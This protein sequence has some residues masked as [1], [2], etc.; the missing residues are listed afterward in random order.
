MS[1]LVTSAKQ[2]CTPASHCFI[3]HL[4]GGGQCLLVRDSEPIK[5]IE[6]PTSLSLYMLMVNKR[7]KIYCIISISDKQLSSFFISLILSLSFYSFLLFSYLFRFN[8]VVS[9]LNV[10]ILFRRHIWAELSLLL[11]TFLSGTFFPGGGGSGTCTQCT[12]C[13]CACSFIWESPPGIY[14]YLIS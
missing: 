8:F 13:I 11:W 10:H 7:E 4:I 9:E 6:I 5:L 12:P 1:F 3:I 14:I 2:D